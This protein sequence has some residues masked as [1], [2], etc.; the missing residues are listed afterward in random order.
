MSHLV[1][2]LWLRCRL[3]GVRGH[4]CGAL[5]PALT[6]EHE[7]DLGRPIAAPLER[8]AELLGLHLVTIGEASGPI[9][10]QTPGIRSLR[11]RPGWSG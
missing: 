7:A 8:C 4:G 6:R 9:R 2:Q 10:M 11:R 5:Q 1:G 3:R